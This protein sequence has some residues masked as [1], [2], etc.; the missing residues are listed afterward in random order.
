MGAQGKRCGK[1]YTSWH[2]SLRG[3]VVLVALVGWMVSGAYAQYPGIEP[4]GGGPEGPYTGFGD[5]VARKG[6]I[7]VKLGAGTL[8]AAQNAVRRKYGVSR[9]SVALLGREVARLFG[10]RTSEQIAGSS[11]LIAGASV[12]T[13]KVMSL[14]RKGQ[15]SRV[16][17]NY[18]VNAFLKPN[19]FLYQL[20]L[21]WHINNTGLF[22]KAGVDV[23]VMSA[24]DSTL[25]AEDLVVAVI[26]S[27][28]DLDHPD[29][30]SNIWRNTAEI[31]NNGLDDDRNGFIDDVSGY[32]FVDDDGD[33]ND[34]M[35]HGT[36]CAAIVAASLNNNR[37]VCGIAPKVKLLPL[38]VLNSR[39][40]GDTA[41]L[42]RAVQYAI[43]LRKRGVNIRVISASLGGGEYQEALKELLDEANRFGILVVAAAG[44]EGSDNDAKP[45]YPA[46]YTS[47]NVISVA[48]LDPWGG[49]ASFSNY[50]ATSV[51]VGA[52]G[53]FIWSAFLFGFYLPFDGTSMA[54]PFVSG[55]AA[56]MFSQRPDLTPAEVI[57][58]IKRTV[59]PLPGLRGKMSAPGML[60]VGAALDG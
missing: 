24:W 59:T 17:K 21:L 41:D 53:V 32:D 3:A 39:G 19:D 46:G 7:V 28:I 15:V 43:S 37:G 51:D 12:N 22:G 38:R 30:V 36:H 44:N 23:N 26:D 4:P 42:M 8:R 47:S 16:E 2:A 25:G 60:N 35:F 5:P 31:P 20:G 14:Q 49:L 13:A 45:T 11:F 54:A 40:E 18:R 1:R 48:A 6:Q 57:E 27:G 52:P 50:G 58:T 33:P 9:A 55:A 34:L 29:L 56:L 10:L